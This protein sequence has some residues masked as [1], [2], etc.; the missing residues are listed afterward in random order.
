[1]HSLQMQMPNCWVGEVCH[2]PYT[3]HTPHST[4]HR[5]PESILHFGLQG[6]GRLPARAA[7]RD[8]E[9]PPRPTRQLRDRARCAVSSIERCSATGMR[10]LETDR[11]QIA[12]VRRH[13]IP[14]TSQGRWRT[15]RNKCE[16]M[17]GCMYVR[18][19]VFI[20]SLTCG[21]PAAGII[22]M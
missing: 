21:P 3:I 19:Y 5:R 9:S 13:L 12:H 18:R 20:Y 14:G 7:V 16:C 2:M 8:S 1:M 10:G 17:Y 22:C 6:V 4:R 15:G 11:T